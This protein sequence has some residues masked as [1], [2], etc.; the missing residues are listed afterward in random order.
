[1]CEGGGCVRSLDNLRYFHYVGLV[2]IGLKRYKQAMEALTMVCT[3]PSENVS[4]VQIDS[5]KKYI[6]CSLIRK[7]RFVP[8]PRYTP[9][10]LTRYFPKFC[11][12]YLELNLAFDSKANSEVIGREKLRK[13][14]E[15]N[16]ELYLKVCSLS[17]LPWPV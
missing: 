1:M 4:M 9:R 7:Q 6:L 16:A 13:T 17:M 5:Y 12:E 11:S 3:S 2:Q 15:K 8:L 10:I 14:I